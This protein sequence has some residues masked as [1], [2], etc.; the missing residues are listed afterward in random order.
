MIATA[1]ISAIPSLIKLFNSDDRKEGVKELTQTVVNEASKKLGVTLNTKDDVLKHLEQNPEQAIKLREIET[2]H[3]QSIME[4][5][6]KDVQSAR[7]M[8]FNI[9]SSK[10]W[11][12]R[13]TGSLIAMFTVLFAVVLDIYILYKAFNSGIATLNPIV[14]LIAGNVSAR[15]GQVLSFYFGSSKES[16]DS[17]RIV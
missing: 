9:Q 15:A 3:I 16:A 17:K 1:I 2:K 12:V 7:E 4:L 8:N 13:N 14:T 10:D 5:Q 6:L 11:L